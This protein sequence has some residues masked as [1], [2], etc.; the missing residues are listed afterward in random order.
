MWY[1]D[2]IGKLN[3]NEMSPKIWQAIQDSI[4]HDKIINLSK[5]DE[6]EVKSLS[7]GAIRHKGYNAYYGFDNGNAWIIK[8]K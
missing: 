7:D 3:E 8:I 5:E 6:L 1:T 4:K 2:L